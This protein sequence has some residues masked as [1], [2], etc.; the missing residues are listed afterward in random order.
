MPNYQVNDPVPAMLACALIAAGGIVWLLR[1]WEADWSATR[2]IERDLLRW[3]Q[4]P[5]GE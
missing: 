3:V 5:S 2:K 4:F 1:S